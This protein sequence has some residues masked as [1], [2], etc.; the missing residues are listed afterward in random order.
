MYILEK[1]VLSKEYLGDA[2]RFADIINGF[3]FHGEQVIK[4]ENVSEMDT[5]V[6]RIWKRLGWVKGT[7]FY[8]DLLRR[9]QLSVQC[10][11]VGVE[12]Q[13]TI[14]YTLPLRVM[15]YDLQGYEKQLHQVKKQHRLHGDLKQDEFLSGISKNDRLEPVVTVIVYFGEQEWDGPLN[16]HGMLALEGLPEHLCAMVPDYPIHVLDVRRYAHIENFRTDLRI[17]FEF[18]QYAMDKEQLKSYIEEKEKDNLI[19]NE[20]TYDMISLMADVPE[21]EELKEKYGSDKGG[22]YM[23]K[24]WEELKQEIRE[25]GIEAGKEAGVQLTLKVIRLSRED[26]NDREIAKTCGISKRKVR[27]ILQKVS[28]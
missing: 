11:V 25:D 7:V 16:L 13:T 8:R 26:V 22:I 5:A 1:D 24:A 9:V 6:N 27:D 10:I 21:L 2:G 18:M 15:G 3:F 28:F 23:C 4:P 17:L 20:E 19:I 14:D 12:E